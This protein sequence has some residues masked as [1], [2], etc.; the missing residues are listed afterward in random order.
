MGQPEDVA[1]SKDGH[2]DVN[3]VHALEVDAADAAT[4]EREATA[5]AAA[6]AATTASHWAGDP[7]AEKTSGMHNDGGE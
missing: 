7:E 6:D 1:R 5:R 2:A 4:S 3:Q